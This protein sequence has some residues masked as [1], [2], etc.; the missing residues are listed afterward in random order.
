MKCERAIN[1]IHAEFDGETS[2]EQQRALQAHLETC[3]SCRVLQTQ[4]K[5]MAEGFEWLA[6]ESETVPQ[7][8]PAMIRSLWTRR[9]A[10][11]AA[12]AIALWVAWPFGRP[13]GQTQFVSNRESIPEQHTESNFEFELVGE[14]FDKYLAVEQESIEPTVHI[15]WLYRNQG[16]S[17]KSSSL[18]PL[19]RPIHS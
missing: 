12:A 7:T 14:S 2:A 5:A 11:A 9:V 15:V 8:A 4:F 19:T 16:F 3:E 17:K 18:A 1:L 10:V 13:S 6:Q